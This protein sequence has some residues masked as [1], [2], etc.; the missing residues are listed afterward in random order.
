M[1][2]L[3]LTKHDSLLEKWNQNYNEVSSHISQNDHHLNIYRQEMLEKMWRKGNTPA[4]LV[5]DDKIT[6]EKSIQK[7][8]YQADTL[9]KY[10]SKRHI[11]P[12]FHCSI[13]YM[14]MEQW[15]GSKLGKEYVK[16]VYCHP[17]YLAYMH[18]IS[19][20]MQAGWSISWNQDCW[21]KYQ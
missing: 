14:D 1:G 9:R 3:S 15:T 10:N 2:T 20:K 6:M 16:S 4:L 8:H 13:I 7:S 18:S 12:N 21:E 5:G 17:A 11:H 19:C